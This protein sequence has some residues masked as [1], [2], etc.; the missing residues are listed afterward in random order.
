MRA[1]PCAPL[2]EQDDLWRRLLNG[3]VDVVASDHSPAPLDMKT[4]DDFFAIWGGIAGVQSTLAVM[5]ERGYHQNRLP[6]ARIP[7]LTAGFPARRFGLADKGEL[8]VGKDA[9]LT[10]LDLAQSYTLENAAIHHR[11]PTSPYAGAHFRGVIRQTLRRGE[12][13]YRDGTFPSTTHGRLI[14]PNY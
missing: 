7:E 6:L 2:Y 1:P 14:R 11:H 3:S 8:A 4:G 5:L 9:D 12:T 10:I 13:I